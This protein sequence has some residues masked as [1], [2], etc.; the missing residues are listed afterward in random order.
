[1]KFVLNMYHNNNVMHVKFDQAGFGNA[2]AI[3]PELIKI[4]KMAITK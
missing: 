3:A 1:M 2:L 4:I